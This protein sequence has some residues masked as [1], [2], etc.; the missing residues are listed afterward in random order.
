L[1]I[2]SEETLSATAPKKSPV[3]KVP[4]SK[5]STARADHRRMVFA[6]LVL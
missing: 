5:L 2:F 6:V 1:E 4:K 3:L